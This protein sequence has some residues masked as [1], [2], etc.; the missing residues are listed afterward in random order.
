MHARKRKKLK[1]SF[2]EL[3]KAKFNRLVAREVKALQIVVPEVNWERRL[4]L[5]MLFVRARFGIVPKA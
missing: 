5:A 3:P 1:A 2:Y 4:N